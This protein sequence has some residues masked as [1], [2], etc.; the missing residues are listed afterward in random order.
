MLP[1]SGNAINRAAAT[2]AARIAVRRRTGGIIRPAK[3]ALNQVYPETRGSPSA[4][5]GLAA[6]RGAN[7]RATDAVGKLGLTKARFRTMNSDWIKD[8]LE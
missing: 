7:P 1:T 3:G 6:H 8:N 5:K 4:I 2:S